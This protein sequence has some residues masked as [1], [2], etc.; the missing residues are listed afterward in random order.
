VAEASPRADEGAAFIRPAVGRAE[1]AVRQPQF[2]GALVHQARE[3]L[4]GARNT[5]RKHDAG[6]VSGKGD[7]ALQQIVDADL[8]IG[9]QEHRGARGGAVPALPRLRPNRELLVELELALLDQVERDIGGHHLC[10]RSRRHPP[11][12]IL[13]IEDRAR[14]QVLQIGNGSRRF[15]RR[16]GSDRRRMSRALVSR[17][18]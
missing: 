2:L 3:R 14:R 8:F 16:R 10:H 11:V 4:F 1:L 7:D 13:G 15:E 18:E 5:F 17:C 6:V 12:G 9:G